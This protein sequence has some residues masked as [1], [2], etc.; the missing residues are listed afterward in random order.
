MIGIGFIAVPTGNAQ[1]AWNQASQ[2]R[3]TAT[4]KTLGN[5]KWLT[6]SGLNEKAFDMIRSL[7]SRELQVSRRYRVLLGVCLALYS[8]CANFQTD[9]FDT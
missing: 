1:A 2:D 6:I 9:L 3:V 8:V 7:R 5:I 4:S